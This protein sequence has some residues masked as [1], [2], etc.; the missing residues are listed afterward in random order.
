[1]IREQRVKAAIRTEMIA[2]NSAHL[3]RLYGGLSRPH[4]ATILIYLYMLERTS[5]NTTA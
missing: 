2:L 5:R 4:S 3:L 1:M